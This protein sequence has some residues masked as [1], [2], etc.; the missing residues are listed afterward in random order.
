M[1][2]RA[3]QVTRQLTREAADDRSPMFEGFHIAKVV[4]AA[5]PPSGPMVELTKAKAWKGIAF[6]PCFVLRSCL[7][8]VQLLASTKVKAGPGGFMDLTISDSL[9]VKRGEVEATVEKPSAKASQS[10]IYALLQGKRV[11]VYFLDGDPDE[12][13]IFDIL[14]AG[15]LWRSDTKET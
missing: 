8:S 12:P 1:S 14:D 13:I 5:P 15:G 3:D 11:L 4:V 7:I 10:A 2:P 9:G 6:G